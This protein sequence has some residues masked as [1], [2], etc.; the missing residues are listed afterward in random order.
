[1]YLNIADSSIIFVSG[2]TLN[3]ISEDSDVIEK[4]KVPQIDYQKKVVEILPYKEVD[5]NNSQ[6]ILVLGES[7]PTETDPSLR[8][9]V[10]GENIPN[11]FNL[12]TRP[13]NAVVDQ[14]NA[15]TPVMSF[16]GKL[17]SASLIG[18]SSIIS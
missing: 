6:V 13:L 5:P 1:M 7:Y 17:N 10:V 3:R 4:I 16:N 9:S 14:A 11:E 2:N 12:E 18:G 15:K 8:S